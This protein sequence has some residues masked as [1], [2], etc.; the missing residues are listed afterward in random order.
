MR[1]AI[2]GRRRDKVFGPGR[3]I[4]LDRNAKVRIWAYAQGYTALHRRRGQHRGPLTRAHLDVLWALL[5]GFHNTRTGR[6]FPSYEA[7]AEKAK[8]DR[9]TVARAIAALEAGQ[10]LTWENR[11][12]RQRVVTPG[13]VGPV[14]VLVPRRTS[15]AYSFRDPQPQTPVILP[16]SQNS[17][18]TTYQDS[19]C[20]KEGQTIREAASLDP[21]NPLEAMLIR[22]G[23][24]V[25][26]IPD[27][28]KKA[29]C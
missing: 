17:T 23:K 12:V 3:A 29:R 9:S 14:M 24:A 28:A 18:G 20:F 7:I 19:S 1:R 11:L 25:G 2:P 16:K 21:S 27:A 4:P 26:A 13:L 6:C 10:V 8:V 15:N 5:W 22:L